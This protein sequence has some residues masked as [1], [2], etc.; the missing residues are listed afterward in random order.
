MSFYGVLRNEN[1][2]IKSETVTLVKESRNTTQ[3]FSDTM[4]CTCDMC[5]W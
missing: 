2:V 4:V 1:K 5:G 3:R